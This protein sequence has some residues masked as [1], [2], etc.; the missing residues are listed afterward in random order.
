MFG[1]SFIAIFSAYHETYH[2]EL[3]HAQEVTFPI[4]PIIRFTGKKLFS[5]RNLEGNFDGNQLL[6][7]S[8]RL[9]LP[10]PGL[11]SDLVVDIVTSVRHCFP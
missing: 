3:S 1:S 8:I 9:S 7:D 11:R 6:D 2:V 10:Y 4:P 5:F